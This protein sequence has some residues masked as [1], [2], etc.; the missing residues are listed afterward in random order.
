MPPLWKAVLEAPGGASPAAH[1]ADGFVGEHAIRTAAVGDDLDPSRQVA[2]L[3][4]ET[5]GRDRT[6]SGDVARRVLGR[7]SDVDHD[8]VAGNESGGQFVPAHFVELVP[9]PEVGGR[10]RIEL[11]VMFGRHIAQGAPQLDD[12]VRGEPV[13]DAVL[14]AA[15]DDEADAGEGAKVKRGIGD[16]LTDLVGELL[17]MSLALGEHVDQLSAASVRQRLGDPGEPIEQRI[18]RDPITH[19]AFIQSAQTTT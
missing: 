11:C 10:E 4:G 19:D 12:A 17:Y 13:V 18:L 5:L 6:G 8:D 9:M 1:E 15:S 7:R 2:E 3:A 14:V 16:G